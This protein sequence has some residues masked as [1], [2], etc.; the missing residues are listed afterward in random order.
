M[1][2]ELDGLAL[3]GTALTAFGGLLLTQ[4]LLSIALNVACVVLAF[5][6]V[7]RY[8]LALRGHDHWA[9]LRRERRRR[10]RS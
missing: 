4:G 2:R 5:V 10:R 6:V 9:E 1:S 8:V 3:V 7:Y